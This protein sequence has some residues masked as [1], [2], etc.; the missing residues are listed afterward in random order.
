MFSSLGVFFKGFAPTMKK[1]ESVMHRSINVV[2]VSSLIFLRCSSPTVPRPTTADFAV[3]FDGVSGAIVITSS[4]ALQL[5]SLT[6]EMRVRIDSLQISNPFLIETGKNQWNEADGF[7]SKVED[8]ALHF[9]FAEQSNAAVV[10]GAP[11]LIQPGV[12]FHLAYTYDKDTMKIFV[13]GTLA[14]QRPETKSIFYG[15]SGFSLGKASF[16][17]YVGRETVLN[18]CLDDV[19]IWNIVRSP[20][21]IQTAMNQ[22][23]AGDEPGLAGYWDFVQF[24]SDSLAWDKTANNNHGTILGNVKFVLP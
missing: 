8:S 17:T 12:W 22:G 19:R 21:E 11:F 4:P 1:G 16:N 9:R 10:L 20:Q 5:D 3:R 14:N 13:N 2:L 6:L 24:S 18:G 7:S 23:L 15:G